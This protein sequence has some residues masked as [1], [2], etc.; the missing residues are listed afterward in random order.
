M[1][2]LGECKKDTSKSFNQSE[3]IYAQITTSPTIINY[4]F[5]AGPTAY[6]KLTECS[7]SGPGNPFNGVTMTA[8][9][10]PAGTKMTIDEDM[11]SL[12]ASVAITARNPGGGSER[13]I[14]VGFFL[15]GFLIPPAI[16]HTVRG[17]DFNRFFIHPITGFV[18]AGT[19]IEIGLAVIDGNA[20]TLEVS[21]VTIAINGPKAFN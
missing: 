9:P 14:G 12:R 19:E 3:E 5:G 18:P 15:N 2:Y 1:N 10:A 11:E 8:P 7:I 16:V 6:Q 13:T 17:T 21:H 20:M 4:I